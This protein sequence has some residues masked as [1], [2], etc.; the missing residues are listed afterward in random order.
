MAGLG[1]GEGEGDG[2]GVAVGDGLGDAVGDGVGVANVPVFVPQLGLSSLKSFAL[3][4]RSAMFWALTVPSELMTRSAIL[5][6]KVSVL[7]KAIFL[8]SGENVALLPSTGC[9]PERI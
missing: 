3:D 7:R 5:S 6:L 2:V 1:L 4:V 8:S 9:V